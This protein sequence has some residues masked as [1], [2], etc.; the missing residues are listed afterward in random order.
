[1]ILCNQKGK[2]HSFLSTLYKLQFAI[3]GIYQYII[4]FLFV[5]RYIRCK[6]QFTTY[7]TLLHVKNQA[8][9]I[10]TERWRSNEKSNQNGVII[11]IQLSF[12]FCPSRSSFEPTPTGG[13]PSWSLDLSSYRATIY[14]SW[15][16]KTETN[17]FLNSWLITQ[18]VASNA[19][20]VKWCACHA[21]Q[22]MVIYSMS[23]AANVKH[24][25]LHLVTSSERKASCDK[26][27]RQTSSTV[28]RWNTT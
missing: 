24:G 4:R 16:S 27:F 2:K 15:Q 9:Q 28:Q 19:C 22:S 5:C 7:S 26:G 14:Q 12:V 21:M 17:V 1:M 23:Q 13:A 10:R 8:W 25:Q 18:K 3:C 6:L 20:H 11:K